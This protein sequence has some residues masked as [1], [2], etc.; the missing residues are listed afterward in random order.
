MIGVYY[1]P[2]SLT[3]AK[4]EEVGKKLEAAGASRKGLKMHSCFGHDGELSVFEVWETQGEYDAH[5][6]T[7]LSILDEA[8]VKMAR[9]ADI[10]PM[11]SLDLP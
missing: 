1:S 9:P 3:Q 5:A 8:G 11:V 6:A 4:Y 10:V 7:L 2:E